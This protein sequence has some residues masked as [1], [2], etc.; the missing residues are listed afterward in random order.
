[1]GRF[2]AGIMLGSVLITQLSF[3]RSKPVQ[4]ADTRPIPTVEDTTPVL[5]ALPP[6]PPGKS[7]VIGGAIRVVD[8][9]RDQFILKVFG[10]KSMKILF[11]ARTQFYRDGVK[12]SV[13][14]LHPVSHASVET[15]LDGTAI[16][17][18]SIHILSKSPEGECDGQVVSYNSGTGELSVSPVLAR[19]PIRLRV[20]AGTPIVRIGQAAASSASS[21]SAGLIAGS[22]I[23]LTFV[24]GSEGRGVA[25]RIEVLAAPGDSFVFSGNITFLDLHA[26]SFALVDP[27]DEKNYKISFDPARFPA[28]KYLHTGEHVVVNATFDG[29]HY[30]ANEIKMDEVT[31]HGSGSH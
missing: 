10:G 19:E 14:D 25:R 9:V 29:T 28:S 16:F 8:P 30:V 17:A 31:Q 27:R 6:T 12:S 7:T 13:R 24:S 15:V 4:N 3:A 2:L 1:M 11:D 5:P 23:S 26:E 20:P 18:R 21:G 22:L